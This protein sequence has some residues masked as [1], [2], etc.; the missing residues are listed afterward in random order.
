MNLTDISTPCSVVNIFQSL[1]EANLRLL[2]SEEE[3]TEGIMLF[4][5]VGKYLQVDMA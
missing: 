2:Y 4:R 1:Q 5:K 3:E